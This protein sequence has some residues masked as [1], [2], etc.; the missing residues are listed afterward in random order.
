M[1]VADNF[2]G[3]VLPPS[4]GGASPDIAQQRSIEQKRYR[5]IFLK[6][7]F[8]FWWYRIL[9]V[10]LAGVLAGAVLSQVALFY[11]TPVYGGIIGSVVLFWVI[12][13]PTFG[14]LL[15]TMGTTALAPK[16]FSIKSLDIYPVIL[17]LVVL[18]V[19]LIVQMT[20]HL[21][22][23]VFPSFWAIWP[24]LGLIVMAIISTLIVQ[25]FWTHSVPHKING[26][27]ILYSEFYGIG[28]FFIPLVA[29]AVT[30]IILSENERLIR[31]IQYTNMLLAVIA[32]LIIFYEYRRIGADIYTFR[33][34][35]PHILWMSL[36]AMAQLLSMGSVIAYVR[37]LYATTWRTRWFYLVIAAMCLL[38]VILSLE[39]SWWLEI[40]VAY[41]VITVIYSRRLII[42]ACIAALPLLPLLKA[43]YSKLQQVKQVDAIRLLIWQDALRVWS[44][45]PLF[46]VGPG[47]FWEYD[48]TFTNLPR[49][50]RNFN[51]TG[52]GVAH[53]GYLQ[54]L[55]ELGPIGLFFQL[56]MIAVLIYVAAQFFFRSPVVK[57]HT[58]GFFHLIDLELFAKTEKLED[59]ILGLIV[60]GIITGSAV[61]DFVSGSFFLPARQVSSLNAVPEPMT[62]WFLVGCLLYKDQLWRMAKKGIKLKEARVGKPRIVKDD[63]DSLNLGKWSIFRN[64]FKVIG[65]AIK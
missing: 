57:K 32:A 51:T 4:G 16:L 52:L 25:A 60:I 2:S 50:L 54:I 15:T 19:V 35:E 39:N 29:L 56:S 45:Q 22:K 62:T 10:V 55:G 34:S 8:Q 20:F 58:R 14:L 61:A 13:K 1:Q 23:P 63:I 31:V 27:P 5:R 53:N 48:Q 18:S 44:K 59:R 6:R 26:N 47:D 33:Y 36:R 7:T 65:A 11:S 49:A 40:G 28:L 42:S 17:L 38:A 24:Q 3:G 46:G 12:K 43:E 21:R 9:I 64:L 30:T 37:F 41:V